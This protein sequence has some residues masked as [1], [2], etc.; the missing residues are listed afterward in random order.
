MSWVDLQGAVNVRD[1]GG[2]PTRDG[3]QTAHRRV[4]RA[5]NLQGLTPGDVRHLVEDLRVSTVVDLRS[6]GEVELEG[7]G[8]LTHV[9][10]LTF[11]HQSVIP[12]AGR[13]TDAAADGLLGLAERREHVLAHYPDDPVCA[14]YLGYVTDRPDS[15][16]GALRAIAGAPGAAIVHCA[17]GKDRTGVV[18]A[19]A[20]SVVNVLPEAIV[21][22]YVASGER[23]DA[24]MA[25]LAASQTY[26]A[27]LDKMP[28]DV[29]KPR[30]ETM[31]AFL[32]QLDARY[33]GVLSWLK[34]HGY[35]DSD[36]ERLRAKLL[37]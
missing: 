9:G 18:I 29:H 31:L 12:E 25:R 14:Y 6:S 19:L 33:D 36:V 2:L 17:A 1:V 11:V 30:A 23:I 15:V 10:S 28:A 5:D 4:V 8:P 22:D 35:D 34:A 7:P 16:V 32:Q 21:E 26:A 27:D 24:I 13:A 3:G 20:L 37:P